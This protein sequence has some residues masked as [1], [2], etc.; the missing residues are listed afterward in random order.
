MS[1]FVKCV[2]S[3]FGGRGEEERRGIVDV[4]PRNTRD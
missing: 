3:F 2:S 4:R 1:E